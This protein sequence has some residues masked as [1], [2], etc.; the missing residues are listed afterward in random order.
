MV[1]ACGM[2]PARDAA[3]VRA[4]APVRAVVPA[5]DAAQVRAVVPARDAAQGWLWHAGQRERWV[6]VVV[7]VM[8]QSRSRHACS[9]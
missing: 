4:V 2:A 6:E 5:R 8:V 7:R 1:P 3:L 9:A